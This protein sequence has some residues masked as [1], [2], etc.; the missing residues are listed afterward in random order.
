MGTRRKAFFLLGLLVSIWYR[1]P[2][3]PEGP[4][5]PVS[6]SGVFG[7]RG[8]LLENA[9]GAPGLFREVS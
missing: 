1:I 7:L 6:A 5:H 8:C 4:T 3:P 2:W 9:F